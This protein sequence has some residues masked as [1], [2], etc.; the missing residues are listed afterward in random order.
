M[1]AALRAGEIARQRLVE[2][3]TVGQAGQRI[4]AG[5]PLERLGLP[6]QALGQL[7]L[8]LVQR[9]QVH[10]LRLQ[11]E[12]CFIHPPGQAQVA[13]LVLLQQEPVQR[14]QRAQQQQADQRLHA[15]PLPPERLDGETPHRFLLAPGTARMRGRNVQ[16][17]ITRRQAD[18]LDA[19]LGSTLDP[20]S[21]QAFQPCAV[22]D[23]V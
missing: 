1:A 19:A 10:G 13:G 7:G 17:V 18:E 3:A 2:A 16:G 6:R 15:V 21:V 14:H 5:L 23:A 4:L 22:T 20:A 8:F 12:G 11:V 9:L